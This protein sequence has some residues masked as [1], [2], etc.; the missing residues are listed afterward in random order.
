MISFVVNGENSPLELAAL[1]RREASRRQRRWRPDAKPHKDDP[2]VPT[3]L[4]Q[5]AG[6]HHSAVEP[7]TSTAPMRR[8]V[9]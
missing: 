7:N 9:M 4:K 3:E 1:G 5:I 8:P 2:N 6:S